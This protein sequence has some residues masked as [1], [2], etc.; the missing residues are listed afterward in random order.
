MDIGE[1]TFRELS[2]K[3]IFSSHLVACAVIDEKGYVKK[4]T[5]AMLERFYIKTEILR[6][7]TLFEVLASEELKDSVETHR[8]VGEYASR[9]LIAILSKRQAYVW[10]YVEVITL[11]EGME[12]TYYMLLFQDCTESYQAQMILESSLTLSKEAFIFLDNMGCL[13]QCSKEAVRV[14]GFPNRVEALGMSVY[15]FFGNQVEKKAVDMMFE[16][17]RDGRAVKREI[18]VKVKGSY[19]VYTMHAFNVVVKGKQTGIAICLWSDHTERPL[20]T[21][22]KIESEFEKIG[23]ETE[24]KQAVFCESSYIEVLQELKEALL[25]YDYVYALE[26][27]E[28]LYGISRNQNRDMFYRIKKE[29]MAFRYE[30][31]LSILDGF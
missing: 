14:F 2:Y 22:D 30:K 26:I 12:E 16:E 23:A 11:K 10:N 21:Q 19:K 28:Y 8:K 9:H 5:K 3:A 31:A 29:I 27:T 20:V 18:S 17:L 25:F 24:E 4:M 15:S 1:K 13:L 6:T 7:R